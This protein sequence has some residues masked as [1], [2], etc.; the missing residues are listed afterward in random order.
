M[1][2]GIE[3]SFANGAKLTFLSSFPLPRHWDEGDN[4]RARPGGVA[5]NVLFAEVEVVVVLVLVVA[6]TA[7][8]VNAC[9]SVCFG[10]LT[11]RLTGR[12]Q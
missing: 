8:P 1:A 7:W 6:L 9:E 10:L 4:E 12:N 2:H 3:A 11:N 5:N